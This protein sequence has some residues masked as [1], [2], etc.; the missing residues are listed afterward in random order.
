ME[1]FGDE[2]LKP[3]MNCL[4]S[5]RIQ[6]LAEGLHDQADQCVGSGIGQKNPLKTNR[7]KIKKRNYNTACCARPVGSLDAEA[8][9][10]RSVYNV[11]LLRGLGNTR[12]ERNMT[13][14]FWSLVV[15]DTSGVTPPVH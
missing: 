3:V 11:L 5:R 9:I 15:R 6:S 7:I 2:G 10:I 1:G 13:W 12:T 4:D 8:G 14:S